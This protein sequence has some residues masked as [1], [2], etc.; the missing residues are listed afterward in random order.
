MLLLFVM[1]PVAM[2]SNLPAHI[3]AGCMVR[4]LTETPS[5]M[6]TSFRVTADKRTSWESLLYMYVV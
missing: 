4:Q 3:M 2:H 5:S 6:L 1:M